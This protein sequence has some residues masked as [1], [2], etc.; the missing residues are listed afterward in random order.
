MARSNAVMK[1]TVVGDGAKAKLIWTAIDNS[2]KVEL[3]LS[4]LSAATLDAGLIHGFSAK[5]GDAA[6]KSDATAD[7]KFDAMQSVIDNLYADKWR[8]ERESGDAVLIEAILEVQPKANP[9]KVV[10]DLKKMSDAQKKALRLHPPIKKI[11][12]RNAAE[13]VKKSGVKVDELIAGFM[14][15]AEKA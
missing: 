6:A 13:A 2:R 1:R 8:G 4:K 14:K 9:D 15:E 3:D 12:E 5:V 7:E 10:A 11:L